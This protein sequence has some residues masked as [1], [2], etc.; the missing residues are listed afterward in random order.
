MLNQKE[1]LQRLELER[2]GQH[3][4]QRYGLEFSHRQLD[5]LREA[6][7]K[8]CK[9]NRSCNL[10]QYQEL[11]EQEEESLAL[12]QL[13][14]VHE[15]YFFRE[16]AQFDVM[17]QHVLQLTKQKNTRPLFRFLSAGCSTGEEA[18]SIAMALLDLP[19]AG[20]EWDFEVVGVDVDPAAIR[21]AQLGSYGAYS[22]RGC[23]AA[24]RSRHF[25]PLGSDR[26]LINERVKEKVRFETLNLFAP[27]YPEWLEKIDVVFYRNVSIYFSKLQRAQLFKRL[28]GLLTPSGCLFVS[29]TET[30][31]HNTQQMELV[32]SG[33]VFYY[34]K[35]KKTDAPKAAEKKAADTVSFCRMP[36]QKPRRLSKPTATERQRA[37]EKSEAACADPLA[38]VLEMLEEKQYDAA[39]ARL[40]EWIAC[41]PLCT[42]AYT[43]K[44]NILLN[45]QRVEE[46]AEICRT[47]LV[48]DVFCLEA[49]LLLG[50]AA[51]IA[52][53]FEEAIQRL[54]EAVYVSPECWLA[55][56]FL[57]QTYQL[58]KESAYARREYQV[59]MRILEQGG[60]AEHGLS[61]FLLAVQLD[62]LIR[63]C[64]HQIAALNE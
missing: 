12:I 10:A 37:M 5:L 62:D 7:R 18:Y 60:F 40:E 1:M 29:C 33:E 14:T 4:N 22:F 13:L 2:I 52:G 57:A 20:C 55:H 38:K 26:F 32:N 41:E 3:I 35:E 17:K 56:F 30:L 42:K 53:K 44:A 47:V 25:Q 51:K 28:A 34:C 45:R 59:T 11:L 23:S 61:S 31:Y 39:L 43:L 15:T 54:K 19:G 27:D 36:L 6:V 49:Y 8:R 21:K 16:A 63:L 58:R 24:L 9:T 64:R 48:M 50:M 46:A